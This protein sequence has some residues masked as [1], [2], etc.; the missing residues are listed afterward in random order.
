LSCC[1]AFPADASYEHAESKDAQIAV[2]IGR[3]AVLAED[4][5]QVISQRALREF[6]SSHPESREPLFAWLRLI[7]ASEH[8]DFKALRRTFGSAEYLAPFTVFRVGRCDA[9]LISVIHY[10]RRRIFVRQVMFPAQYEEWLARLRK[11]CVVRE[12]LNGVAYAVDSS[13]LAR[14]AGALPS[15]VVLHYERAP[16]QSDE[17]VLERVAR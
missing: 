6:E 10:I 14:A 4:A 7:Q 11:K 12:P 5:V 13:H 16:W 17:R 15:E 3:C 2:A 8:S 1:L 9:R